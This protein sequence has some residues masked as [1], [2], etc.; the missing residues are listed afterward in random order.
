MNRNYDNIF[1]MGYFYILQQA[2]KKI[3]KLNYLSFVEAKNVYYGFAHVSK[4]F[5]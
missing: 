2:I 4:F 5:G 1:V 3:H